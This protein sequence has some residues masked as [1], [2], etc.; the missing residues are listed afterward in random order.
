MS[1]HCRPHLFMRWSL[2]GNITREAISA[3]EKLL[4]LLFEAPVTCGGNR[5]CNICALSGAK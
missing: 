4:L 1:L 2:N 3:D 5:H